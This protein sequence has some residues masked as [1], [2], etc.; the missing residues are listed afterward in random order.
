VHILPSINPVTQRQMLHV[1]RNLRAHNC[2]FI[3]KNRDLLES[4]C[5]YNEFVC[6]LLYFQHNGW[7]RFTITALPL[8]Q[9]RVH[10]HSNK[11]THWS[12]VFYFT[13]YIINK[14]DHIQAT[15]AEAVLDSYFQLGGRILLVL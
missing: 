3:I 5:P 12:K 14:T 10:I 13:F 9:Q 8:E 4:Y 7:K 15:R 11:K 2:H 1:H 6:F